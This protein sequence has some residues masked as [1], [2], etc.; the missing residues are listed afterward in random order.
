MNIIGNPLSIGNASGTTVTAF[1]FGKFSGA[2]QIAQCVAGDAADGVIQYTTDGGATL[3]YDGIV[4]VEAGGTITPDSEVSIDANGKAVAATGGVV[5]GR[6]VNNASNCALGDII[7]V[8]F[9]RKGQRP[10]S[11]APTSLPTA[12]AASGPVAVRPSTSYVVT[13]A[14][15][16]ALTLAAP[17]ATTDDGVI[18]T[19]FSNTAFAHTL[20]ATGLLNTGSASVNVATFAAFAGAGLTL[21]AYQGKWM[22]ISQIGVTFS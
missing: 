10:T 13:K 22:V 3:I 12:I 15:V 7:D 2:S 5:V 9:Y 17:T 6:Y 21:E 19:I 1:R 4:P 11:L 20:T 16:A 14:G 18:I 8:Q